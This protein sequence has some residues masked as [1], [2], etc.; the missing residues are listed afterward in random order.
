M[1]IRA[2]LAVYGRGFFGAVLFQT[3]EQLDS[4]DCSS[5]KIFFKIFPTLLSHAEVDKSTPR[6]RASLSCALI[7][8]VG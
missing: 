6:T 5:F 7:A 2:V 1:S 4:V 3:P 8:H